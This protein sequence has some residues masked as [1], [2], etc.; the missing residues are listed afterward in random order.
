MKTYEYG[1]KI[2]AEYADKAVQMDRLDLNDLCHLLG[3]IET[4]Y[5]MPE[6]MRQMASKLRK[7]VSLCWGD[8]APFRMVYIPTDHYGEYISGKSPEDGDCHARSQTSDSANA[9]K[10]GSK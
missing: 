8:A 6:G 4:E 7:Q 9:R 1:T 2:S 10:R 3:L 5:L